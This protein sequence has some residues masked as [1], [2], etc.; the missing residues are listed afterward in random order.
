M[1]GGRPFEEYRYYDGEIIAAS[2]LGWNFGEG[3]LCNE[4]LL[5]AVQ[6]QCDYDEGELRVL[7]VESQ[8]L[9]GSPLHW[10]IFD[11]RTGLVEEGDV[12]LAELKTRAPWDYGP[13]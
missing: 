10:R 11:A 5:E 3:H 7:T 12:T 2:V 1:L 9:F 4:R 6:H 8:P 13:K